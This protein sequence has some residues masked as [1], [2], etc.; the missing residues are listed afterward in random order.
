MQVVKVSSQDKAISEQ[1]YWEAIKGTK[2]EMRH[3][4]K[5]GMSDNVGS[6]LQISF[7]KFSELPI[8]LRP[9]QLEAQ[10]LKEQPAQPCSQENIFRLHTD[11]KYFKFIYNFKYWGKQSHGRSDD[12]R[13]MA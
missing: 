4:Y 1:H 7:N 6:Q 12:Q 9:F 2:E 8:E 3:C 5:W 13:K 11:R 10:L